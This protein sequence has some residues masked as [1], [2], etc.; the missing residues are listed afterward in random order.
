MPQISIS[1]FRRSHCSLKMISKVIFKFEFHNKHEKD[2]FSYKDSIDM[3]I[4][5]I[6]HYTLYRKNNLLC[7]IANIIYCLH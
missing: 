1:C 4:H 5:E 3:H 7:S 6:F 2:L